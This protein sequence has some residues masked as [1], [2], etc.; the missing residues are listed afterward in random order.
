MRAPYLAMTRLYKGHTSVMPNITAVLMG[1]GRSARLSVHLCQEAH[2]HSAAG[3][4]RAACPR[5]WTRHAAAHRVKNTAGYLGSQATKKQ[6]RDGLPPVC[7]G[8]SRCPE[9]SRNCHLLAGNLQAASVEFEGCT[10]S[11]SHKLEFKKLK[12]W[13]HMCA[14]FPRKTSI[15]QCP[16]ERSPSS[17]PEV[18]PLP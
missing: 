9:G 2:M 1:V 12:M 13:V 11:S 14:N 7:H 8:L 4:I 18:A 3:D 17:G 5:T 16:Y 6:H 15:S 10:P